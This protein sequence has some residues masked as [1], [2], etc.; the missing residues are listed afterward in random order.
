[1][2]KRTNTLH[3]RMRRA[4]HRLI[5]E[6]EER[7]NTFNKVS[8]ELNTKIKNYKTDDQDLGMVLRE[9]EIEE[10]QTQKSE[11]LRQHII[12]GEVADRLNLPP[13]TISMLESYGIESALE[14][15]DDLLYGTPNLRQST[16]INLKQWRA[17]IDQKFVFKPSLG[18]T[19]R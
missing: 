18:M 1:M 17:S 12:R 8:K 10:L 11:F 6:H 13:L 5:A 2:E 7:K 16:M 3:Q 15:D 14:I 19:S 4:T 9:Y